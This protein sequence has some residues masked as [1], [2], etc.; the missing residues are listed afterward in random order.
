MGKMPT[1]EGAREGA[2]A[3]C[4]LEGEGARSAALSV[5]RITV[6]DGRLVCEVR[7]TPAAPRRTSP[8][9]MARVLPFFPLLPQHAC[10][11][12][13]GPRF[14]AV[15]DDTPLPHLLEH[16]VI[17]LQAREAPRAEQ[18]YVGTTDWIDEGQGMA[19][20]QVS[21]TDDLAA[22]RA[23]RDAV[24]FLNESVLPYRNASIQG[25]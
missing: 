9:L 7:L 22:L 2:R 1:G 8:R 6:G 16:L 11:N 24:R 19:R 14:G 23:F 20:V 12:E 4:Q 13:T 21:F 3:K 17:D 15:M 5:E 10:V 25:E 18:V